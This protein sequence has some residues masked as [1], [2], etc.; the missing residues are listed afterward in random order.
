MVSHCRDN[1]A[2]LIRNRIT[3]FS[4]F[5]CALRHSFRF[6]QF[7]FIFLC[8]FLFIR[9]EAAKAF[10]CSSGDNYRE[11]FSLPLSREPFSSERKFFLHP[12]SNLKLEPENS[13]FFFFVKLLMLLLLR[14]NCT[15]RKATTKFCAFRPH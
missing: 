3:L 4:F 14:S 10:F 1:S 6:L 5:F 15:T 11:I 12:N 7:F 13:L 8:T 9:I 2:I